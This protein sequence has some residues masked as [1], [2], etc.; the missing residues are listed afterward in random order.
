M[1]QIS[2]KKIFVK[3]YGCQMNVYDSNRIKNLFENKGYSETNNVEDAALL[4]EVIAGT[5]DFDSTVSSK[6]VE[7]YSKEKVE[8]KLRCNHYICRECFFNIIIRNDFKCP[9][10]RQI[11]I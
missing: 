11:M 10:C 6:S 2:T 7:E 4:L 9:L 8:F 1:N 5:D 3:S